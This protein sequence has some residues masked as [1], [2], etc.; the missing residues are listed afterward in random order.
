M[1]ASNFEV[2]HRKL[3]HQL[4]VGAAF[5]TYLI[6]PEDIVWRFVKNSSRPHELERALFLAATI[7]IC[8]GAVL[9]TWVSAHR[10]PEGNSS[11]EPRR[12]IDG[13]QA[14]G[15]ILYAIGL[16]SLFPSSGFLILVLGETLR[17]LR[18][19]SRKGDPSR[20]GSEVQP[21]AT[22]GSAFRIE[23]VKWGIL[24]TMIVFV[25]TLRDRVAEYLAAASFLIGALLNAPFFNRSLGNDKSS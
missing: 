19:V 4:L 17:V 16:A 11:V 25:I 10:K 14:L 21:N 20:R 24:I 6:D 15:E 18:L 23:A 13:P 2:H 9:C 1:K 8:V 3:L 5:L 22:W 7:A 12:R